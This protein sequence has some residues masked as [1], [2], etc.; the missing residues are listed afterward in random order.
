MATAEV[1][2]EGIGFKP[3]PKLQ[4]RERAYYYRR[5]TVQGGD[6][7]WVRTGLLPSDSQGREYYLTKGFRLTPPGENEFVELATAEAV[8]EK[9]KEVDRL[10]EEV[11]ALKLKLD[12][13][14]TT[15]EVR[16]KGGRPPGS[17]NKPS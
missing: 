7:V 17:K 13:L 5:I 6:M 10:E 8:S 14:K 4:R 16:N 15:D 3:L 11:K 2:P 1:S 12:S 9:Q